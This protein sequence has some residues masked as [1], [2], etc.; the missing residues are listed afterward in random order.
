VLLAAAAGQVDDPGQREQLPGRQHR[1]A[2]AR[3][4]V[5]GVH[6][7]RQPEFLGAQPLGDDDAGA[8]RP[9]GGPVAGRHQEHATGLALDERAE[10]REVAPLEVLPQPPVI[11]RARGQCLPCGGLAGGQRQHEDPGDGGG[12]IP[13]LGQ[14]A[15]GREHRLHL[16]AGNPAE[17]RAVPWHG[18]AGLN[19]RVDLA[20]DGLERPDLRPRPVA[21]VPGPQHEQVV[22][23]H[24]EDKEPARPAGAVHQHHRAVPGFRVVAPDGQRVAAEEPQARREGSV[25]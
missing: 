7:G 16:D 5:I 12:V 6:A 23:L 9:P 11:K 24:G 8:G 22:P 13:R 4:Q 3:S 17:Q 25:A 1:R 21:A 19:Q 14:P 18:N 10:V 2:L 20:G 15:V